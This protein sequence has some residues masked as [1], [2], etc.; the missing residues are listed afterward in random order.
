[1]LLLRAVAARR[2]PLPPRHQ[3][4]LPLALAVT[5]SRPCWLHLQHRKVLLESPPAPRPSL[6][7]L[8]PQ[9]PTPLPRLLLRS[10]LAGAT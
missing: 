3:R 7:A 8:L 6:L 5:P 2:S 1:M 10:R 4:P 9:P